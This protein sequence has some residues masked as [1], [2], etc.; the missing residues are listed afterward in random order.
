MKY[1]L[2]VVIFFAFLS[3]CKKQDPSDRGN[4][5]KDK[6]SSGHVFGL[7]T[8]LG[9]LGDFA[10]ND[11]QYNGMVMAKRQ[12]G[13]SFHY[14]SPKTVEED[15]QMIEE[16]IK[17]GC[18]VIF[19]GGGYHMIDPVDRLAPKY[20]HILFILLDDT[21]KTLYKNVAGI[22]FKQNEGSYLAGI[23]AASMT[24]TGVIGSVAA[25]DIPVINDFLVGYE[26]GAKYVKPNIRIHSLY[27]EKEYNE[28]NPF[29]APKTAYK[30]TKRLITAYNA[31]VIF[32][33][34]SASGTGVFNA[35][36]EAKRFAIG[37]DSDQDYLAKGFVLSSMMKRLDVAIL[38]MVERILANNFENK[39]YS[40]G[41]KENG[42]G[43]SSM[44][45][46]KDIIP[47]GVIERI[48]KAEKDI[49][50]GKLY[51]PS[52]Y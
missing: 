5:L 19:A 38:F 33:V 32:Q 31:D 51:V 20:P 28:K 9:E 49:I 44:Q 15:D 17:K 1:L 50:E 6:I 45:Y 37:V 25:M 14:N 36:Q 4:K 16:L 26:A 48:K 21:P 35:A 46:T 47:Q 3:S 18:N 22:T 40:L 24:K 27:L 8:G 39:V 2:I 10:F 43:L 30:A 7:T 13:I 34:A 23:L 41:L 42:V 11:M 52:A 12:F 29:S